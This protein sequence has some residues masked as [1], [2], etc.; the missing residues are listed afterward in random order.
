MA[1]TPLTA[2]RTGGPRQQ[3]STVLDGV[4]V[5]ASDI[6]G[7]KPGWLVRRFS[8][9]LFWEVRGRRMAGRPHYHNNR[10]KIVLSVLLGPQASN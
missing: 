4:I 10:G 3:N 1:V 7:L 8:V 2:G 9:Q 5:K 6:G